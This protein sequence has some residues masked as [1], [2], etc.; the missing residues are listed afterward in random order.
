MI[1]LKYVFAA[2]LQGLLTSRK[3]SAVKNKNKLWPKI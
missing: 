3:R 2:A 1:T